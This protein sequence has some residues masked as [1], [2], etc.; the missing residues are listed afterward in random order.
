MRHRAPQ[1][2]ITGGLIGGSPMAIATGGLLQPRSRFRY[3]DGGKIGDDGLAVDGYRR[4][5]TTTTD[6]RDAELVEGE[7][8]D[9]LAVLRGTTTA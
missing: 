8:V 6:E 5:F 4:T 2:I 1:S 9:D 3:A 7:Y